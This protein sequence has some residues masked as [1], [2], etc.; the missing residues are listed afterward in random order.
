[1]K[2]RIKKK[3]DGKYYPQVRVNFFFWKTLRQWWG[4]YGPVYGTDGTVV[5]NMFRDY[6]VCA[7]GGYGFDTIESAQEMID[8]L[9]KQGYLYDPQAVSPYFSDG[10]MHY[11]D[12]TPIVNP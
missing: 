2:T 9:N 5:C 3:R 4:N 10:F 12:P 8:A 1:M 11:R 7:F 6:R